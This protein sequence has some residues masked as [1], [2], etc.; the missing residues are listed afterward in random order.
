[1]SWALQGHP[2]APVLPAVLAVAEARGCSG[3]DALLA[4]V[5]GFEVEAR[6]GQALSRSHYARGWHPTSTVGI[7]GATAAASRLLGLDHDAVCT[8]FGIACSRA[9]GSRMNFGTDTKPLHAGFA[10]RDG[11]ESARLSARG[12]TAHTDGLA[13]PMGFADLY[14]GAQPLQL[15]ELGKQFALERPGVELKP[16]ASCRFT[17]RTI[18]AVLALRERHP[19]AKID[20]LECEIDPFALQI[21]IHPQ[22]RTGLEAKFS[23]PY[24]AAVSWLD[25]VPGLSSFSDERASREDVQSLLGTVQVIHASDASDSVTVVLASG[26]RDRE[27]VRLGRGHPQRPLERDARLRKVRECAEDVLGA[28]RTRSVIEAV[29]QLEHLGSIRALGHLLTPS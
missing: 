12:V 21:L 15:A 16:Y 1:V 5:I 23:L 18:D 8:A 2:S 3:A 29:E 27:S 9:A 7:F 26:E 22:P 13:A 14:S 19:D 17:H 25:G 10:A 4:Y 20:R 11:V 28:P 24:C 6:I